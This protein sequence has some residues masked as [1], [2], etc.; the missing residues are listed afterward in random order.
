MP[1][2]HVTPKA[3]LLSIAR[4][5]LIPSDDYRS[6]NKTA[7]RGKLIFVEPD[8]AG[9]AV[10]HDPNGTSAML[11]LNRDGHDSTP[12][13]EAVLKDK[14]HPDEIQVKVGDGWVPLRQGRQLHPAIHAAWGEDVSPPDPDAE[15]RKAAG[16]CQ[17]CWYGFKD[18]QA[19]GVHLANIAKAPAQ[20]PATSCKMCWNRCSKSVTDRRPSRRRITRMS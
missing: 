18:P 10:Y 5:G 15:Q 13:G 9:A 11:R 17:D 1:L 3:N 19:R 14:V 2:Y 16:V 6:G 8:E 20:A 7:A 4:R 12:D